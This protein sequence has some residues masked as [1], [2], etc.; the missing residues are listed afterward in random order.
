MHSPLNNITIVSRG[1]K[2]PSIYL[3][4]VLF[5]DLARVVRLA[6]IS[7]PTLAF[8]LVWVLCFLAESCCPALRALDFVSRWRLLTDFVPRF[9]VLLFLKLLAEEPAS[10]S[11]CLET[12]LAGP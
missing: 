3:P 1:G 8:A 7:L 9:E 2:H 5:L 4:F 12:L 10:E 6:F 11:R